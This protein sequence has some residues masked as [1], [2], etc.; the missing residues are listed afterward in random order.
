ML[1]AS[2]ADTIHASHPELGDYWLVCEGAAELLFTENETN[3]E[4]LFPGSKSESPYVKDG[5]DNFVVHG[6]QDAVNP[7]RQG[8]KVAAHYRVTVA[9]GGSSTVRLRLAGEKAKANLDLAEEARRGGHDVTVDN[10]SHT[11][12]APRL[13]RALPQP[14]LDL[15]HDRFIALLSDDAARADLRRAVEAIG[16][17]RLAPP[18]AIGTAATHGSLRWK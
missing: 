11:D 9:P 18:M 4:R 17:L 15:P 14:A 6:R 13:S 5:I 1:D 2:G 8:T 10:D 3:N 12:L 16:E 7:D